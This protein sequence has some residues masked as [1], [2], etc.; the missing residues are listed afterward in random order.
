MTSSTDILLCI[1]YF[2]VWIL[3]FIW[4]HIKRF[5]LDAG[6]VII[7]MQI[8]YAIFSVLTLTDELFS[9]AFEELHF[10]PYLYLYSMMMI[11]IGPI[12][13]DHIHI[14]PHSFL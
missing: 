8:N 4:Y 1:G 6:S 14:F 3:T 2:V 12:I 9:M 13:Y 11:A 5:A 7:G 10:F